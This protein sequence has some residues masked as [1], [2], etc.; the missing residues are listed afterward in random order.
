MLLF[1]KKMNFYFFY[2]I[3]AGAHI[4]IHISDFIRFLGSNYICITKTALN[5]PI[6][7]YPIG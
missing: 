3:P 5:Q 1:G 4:V 2:W 7:E 6:F